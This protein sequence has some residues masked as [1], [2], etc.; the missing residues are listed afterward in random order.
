MRTM[1]FTLIELLVVIAIIAILAGMLL[2]A[3]SSAREKA[4]TI[5]CAGNSRQVEMGFANY[6][7][8]MNDWYVGHWSMSGTRGYTKIAEVSVVMLAQSTESG[9]KY[10]NSHLGYLDWKSGDWNHKKFNGVMQCPSFSLDKYGSVHFG[11]LFTVNDRPT[12]DPLD[13][14][15][16]SIK[17]DG[18]KTFYK[19][20]SVSNPGSTAAICETHLY[21]NSHTNFRHNTDRSV[22]NFTFLDGHTEQVRI[23]QTGVGAD[24]AARTLS[25]TSIYW[26]YTPRR[27]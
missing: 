25:M 18:T 3:L 6:C 20:D 12:R 2:P 8:D 17:K 11:A 22:A 27:P 9:S 5:S 10:A 13:P 14:E 7:Q 21:S 23:T 16:L 1:S 19:R 26:P 24:M 15:E 4:K